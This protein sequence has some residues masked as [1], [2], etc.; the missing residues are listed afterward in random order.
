MVNEVS[1]EDRVRSLIA[2]LEG[3]LVVTQGR[4]AFRSQDECRSWWPLE[5]SVP[6]L[7][8]GGYEMPLQVFAD[9]TLG[10]VVWG[11]GIAQWSPTQG[12]WVVRTKTPFTSAFVRDD[13]GRYW[14]GT[15]VGVSQLSIAGS[16]WRLV[17]AGLDGSVA[18]LVI[19][20]SGYLIAAIDDRGV[21]R[22][23]L[24]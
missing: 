23:R 16:D 15:S 4:Q 6:P 21:F 5:T 8:G 9:S 22:A 19:D 12:K 2:T 17:S 1:P 14:L 20:P 18:A 24:P 13:R 3:D 7:G 11:N 10:T